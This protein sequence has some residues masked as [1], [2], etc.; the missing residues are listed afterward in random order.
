MLAIDD[1]D[2]GLQEVEKPADDKRVV[3]ADGVELVLWTV[4]NFPIRLKNKFASLAKMKNVTI[5]ELLE[6]VL[7]DYVKQNVEAMFG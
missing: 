6:D 7:E 3:R 5:P 1:K 2:A 4:N